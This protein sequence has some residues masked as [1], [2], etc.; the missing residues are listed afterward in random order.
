M[1][2]R[3]HLE[4]VQIQEVSLRESGAGPGVWGTQLCSVVWSGGHRYALGSG[5]GLLDVIRRAGQSRCPAESEAKLFPGHGCRVAPT[6]GHVEGRGSA[7]H[8]A[9]PAFLSAAGACPCFSPNLICSRAFFQAGTSP[10]DTLD[11]RPAW[12]GTHMACRSEGP[13]TWTHS[14][15]QENLGTVPSGPTQTQPGKHVTANRYGPGFLQS[16][17]CRASRAPQ[18][19]PG[20]CPAALSSFSETVRGLGPSHSCPLT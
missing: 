13:A 10:P 6:L 3:P 11:L 12:L 18:G 14:R 2:F 9:G 1:G 20:Y 8:T 15:R 5:L 17:V 4:E 19:S 7:G 16:L